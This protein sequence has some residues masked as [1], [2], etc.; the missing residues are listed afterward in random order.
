MN[1]GWNVKAIKSHEYFG[2]RKEV[3]LVSVGI[4]LEVL[5]KTMYHF[6][7]TGDQVEILTGFFHKYT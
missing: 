2:I 6:R 3:V 4:N 1:I 7:N 5:R